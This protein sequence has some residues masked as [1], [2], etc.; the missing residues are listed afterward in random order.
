MSCLTNLLQRQIVVVFLSISL[1][2]CFG[3]SKEPSHS[4]GSF[5]YPQ[6][7]FCRVRTDLEKYMNLTLVL[8]NSWNLKNG[9]FVIEFSTIILEN[10]D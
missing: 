8:E 6:H 5:D 2:V 9:P 10:V 1:N 7:M 3:C 4:D